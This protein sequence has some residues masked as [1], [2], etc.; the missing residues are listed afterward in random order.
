MLTRLRTCDDDVSMA[1]GSLEVTPVTNVHTGV[2]ESRR[3]EVRL[4]AE[5]HSAA[6]SCGVPVE[7]DDDSGGGGESC[8]T[9]SADGP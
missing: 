2:L 1:V 5:E 4:L 7:G 9:S 8:G 3:L 6:E